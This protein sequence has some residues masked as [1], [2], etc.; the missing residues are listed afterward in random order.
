MFSYEKS[1]VVGR[2]LDFAGGNR[3]KHQMLAVRDT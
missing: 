3:E 1:E 2:K